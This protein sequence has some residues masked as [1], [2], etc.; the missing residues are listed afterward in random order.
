MH[1]IHRLVKTISSV[2]VSLVDIIAVNVYN[3]TMEIS[4]NMV[5]D[6]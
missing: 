5:C 2:R 3:P 4:V 6:V 1:V